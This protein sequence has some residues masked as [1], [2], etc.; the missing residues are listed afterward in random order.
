MVSH[1]KCL[2]NA[3]VPIYRR[4]IEFRSPLVSQLNLKHIV[5]KLD[6]LK[7]QVM[8][9]QVV[10]LSKELTETTHVFLENGDVKKLLPAT[11]PHEVLYPEMKKTFISLFAR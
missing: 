1:F 10:L 3:S 7:L 8:H 2:M 9:K 11:D 6:T 5:L 4:S